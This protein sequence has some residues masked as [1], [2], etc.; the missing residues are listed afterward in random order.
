MTNWML[1]HTKINAL[2]S[3]ITDINWRNGFTKSAEGIKYNEW[4]NSI[5]VAV[6][7]LFKDQVALGWVDG[8][9]VVNDVSAT[10][11]CAAAAT[12]VFLASKDQK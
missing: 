3:V 7:K 1:S 10:L 9:R 2:A 5:I 11:L 8:S 6:F 4:Q 12:T